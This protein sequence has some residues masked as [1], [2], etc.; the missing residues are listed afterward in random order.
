M[1]RFHKNRPHTKW[2]E[3]KLSARHGICT[4][5][6]YLQWSTSTRGLGRGHTPTECLFYFPI[7]DIPTLL[8]RRT[9]KRQVERS[10][11]E[12][13]PSLTWPCT[14]TLCTSRSYTKPH[15]VE[16]VA[17]WSNHTAAPYVRKKPTRESASNM[18]YVR[19]TFRP[20]Y[21]N[22]GAESTDK[23]LSH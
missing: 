15:S 3:R 9:Y 8:L 17:S 1:L 22:D 23:K 16:T 18:L 11:K 10:Q 6:F 12:I 13:H 19:R 2:A 21:T 20:P 4:C 5:S 14:K 7:R